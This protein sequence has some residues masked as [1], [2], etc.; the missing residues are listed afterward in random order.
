MILLDKLKILVYKFMFCI[1]ALFT[2]IW[3]WQE[4]A[5]SG[6]KWQ[7]DLLLKAE[8][9]K[10]YYKVIINKWKERKGP[11]QSLG[12]MAPPPWD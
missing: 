6:G 8:S 2:H 1:F 5:C 10:R 11:N 7:L 9:D 3:Q 12:P 4:A